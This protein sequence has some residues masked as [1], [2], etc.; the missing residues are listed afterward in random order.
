MRMAT[1]RL[2]PPHELRLLRQPV[3]A[4]TLQNSPQQ[5]RP[6]QRLSP[7]RVELYQQGP[8]VELLRCL[9]RIG[10]ANRQDSLYVRSSHAVEVRS[11]GGWVPVVVGRGQRIV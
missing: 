2:Q 4:D 6:S 1:G 7:S 10:Y 8:R 3:R 11:G 9:L 5:Y